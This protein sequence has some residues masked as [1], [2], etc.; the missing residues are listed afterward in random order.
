[1][2]FSPVTQTC[3]P[4]RGEINVRRDLTEVCRDA[5]SQAVTIIREAVRLRGRC[6]IVLAGGSTPRSLYEVWARD[7]ATKIPWPQVDL[8]WGDE[9]YVPHD[10][11]RSNY[12]M[13]RESL[14]GHVQIPAGNVHRMDTSF[15]DIDEAAEAYER[16]LKRYFTGA[17]PDFDLVLL[18][19]GTDGH[20]ASLFPGSPAVEE[21]DRWVVAVDAPADPP[22]RLSLTLPAINAAANVFVIAAGSD[23]AEAVRCAL[24]GAPNVDVCPASG[25]RPESGRLS[26]WLDD[27][28]AALARIP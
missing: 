26:W 14:L 2:P 1:M 11:R 7:L 21:T 6:S 9:R 15:A 25:I 17:R 18:G 19:I 5:A 28:A 23:K 3:T 10:D 12:R 13:A 16:L 27:A 8:F 20:T 4:V 22:K 24:E